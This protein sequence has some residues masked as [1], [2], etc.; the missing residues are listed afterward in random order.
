MKFT[1]I[2]KFLQAISLRNFIYSVH[3]KRL[4]RNEGNLLPL[5]RNFMYKLDFLKSLNETMKFTKHSSFSL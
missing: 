3:I 1:P 4:L 5:K 2:M